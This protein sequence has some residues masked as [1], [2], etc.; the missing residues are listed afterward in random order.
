MTL[1]GCVVPDILKGRSA[2]GTVGPLHPLSQHNIPEELIFHQ[3]CCKNLTS[4]TSLFLFL[5]NY[6]STHIPYKMNLYKNFT[7]KHASHCN[8]Q[9]MHALLRT[10]G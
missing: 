4:C 9:K 1:G 10:T 2:F 5:F 3:H 8:W 7:L 6:C